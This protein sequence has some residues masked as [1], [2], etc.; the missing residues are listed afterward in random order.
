M[1]KR[2]IT[3]FFTVRS[4]AMVDIIEQEESSDV[5]MQTEDV[6]QTDDNEIAGTSSTRH[7]EE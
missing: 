2:K 6:T 7:V 4:S 1:S 5:L 3:D